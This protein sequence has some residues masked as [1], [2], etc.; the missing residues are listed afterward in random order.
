MSWSMLGGAPLCPSAGMPFYI[1]MA[2]ML[3]EVRGSLFIW[4][5]GANAPTDA[6]WNAYVTA[7]VDVARQCGRVRILVLPEAAGPTPRQRKV[8]AQALYGLPQRAAVITSNVIHLRI[9]TVLR[10]LGADIQAFAP[11]DRIGAAEYLGITADED[12]WLAT[13]EAR[14]R[15]RLGLSVRGERRSTDR[16]AASP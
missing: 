3:Y 15:A 1:E 16:W 11:K 9:N 13:A 7:L 2:T 6:E 4:V 14:L 8:L 10:W 12:A 5:G